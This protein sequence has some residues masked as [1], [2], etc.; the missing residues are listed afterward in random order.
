MNFKSHRDNYSIEMGLLTG[1]VLTYLT[2]D[3][4]PF[5]AWGV[6]WVYLFSIAVYHAWKGD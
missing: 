1:S 3:F 5:G 4:L 6:V 2:S